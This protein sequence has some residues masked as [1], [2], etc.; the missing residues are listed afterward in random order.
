MESKIQVFF[1]PFAGGNCN[2]YN[3]LKI[4][5]PK[6]YELHFLELPGR[7]KRYNQDLILTVHKAIEDY[8]V[9]IRKLRKKELKYVIYGH[10][11]GANLGLF[12]VNKMISDRD[13]PKSFV[14]SGS[15]GPGI[16]REY[17]NGKR[18]L[19]NELDFK[20]ELRK[21]GGIP[22]EIFNNSDLYSFFVPLIRSD[23]EIM[24]R[25]YIDE[26]HI[27]ID[28]PIFA[29]MGNL[30]EELIY[31]ENWK[32]FT[33]NKFEYKIFEGNHFFILD[34]PEYVANIIKTSSN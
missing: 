14:V 27:S 4:F 13:K 26:N 32:R 16:K 5:F 34:C 25:D 24:E 8:V 19:M 15:A 6:K 10:S 28:I 9:Q 21:L 7:G 22:S 31:I 20:D 30:E 2:S 1:L 17:R 12:V 11:M 33:S 3:F 18:Y 23:F 29:L